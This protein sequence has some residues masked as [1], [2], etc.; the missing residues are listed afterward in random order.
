MMKTPEEIKEILDRMHK[1]A[2]PSL[3][4]NIEVQK[5][6]REI[7]N[8]TTPNINLEDYKDD[9]NIPTPK[10]YIQTE[11]PILYEF[12]R[13][14]TIFLQISTKKNS[15]EIQK[16]TSYLYSFEPLIKQVINSEHQKTVTSKLQE[17]YMQLELEIVKFNQK[18]NHLLDKNKESTTLEAMPETQKKE[19][20]T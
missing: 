5:A 17:S 20:T 2:Y 11:L 8:T 12:M 4:L 18:Y 10:M 7:K 9:Y 14:R 1:T 19:E 3:A 13:L 15:E 16:I 6:K